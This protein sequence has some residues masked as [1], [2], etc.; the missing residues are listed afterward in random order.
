MAQG[1]HA[2]F[3]PNDPRTC[4]TCGKPL[5]VTGPLAL[6]FYR[7]DLTG[8]RLGWHSVTCSPFRVRPEAVESAREM[9]V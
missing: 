2:T 3:A 4:C 9:V 8:E 1:S 5:R 7:D 6:T